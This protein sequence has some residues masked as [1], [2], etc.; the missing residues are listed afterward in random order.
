M[1]SLNILVLVYFYKYLCASVFDRRKALSQNHRVSISGLDDNKISCDIV[2]RSVARVQVHCTCITNY[3]FYFL[4]P[5][6][7]TIE[8]KHIYRIETCIILRD[9]ST[10]TSLP[11]VFIHAWQMTYPIEASSNRLAI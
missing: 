9:L 2:R 8:L 10:M 6:S 7:C 11:H 1:V 3:F 4:K 5:S